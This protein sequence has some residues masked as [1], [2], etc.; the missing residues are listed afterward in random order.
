MGEYS[1]ALSYYEKALEIAQET[2]PANHPSLA[3]S[4]NNVGLVYVYLK[5]F[6][7]NIVQ[8]FFTNS[9]LY[10]EHY[11]ICSRASISFSFNKFDCDTQVRFLYFFLAKHQYEFFFKIRR[12]CL[13]DHVARNSLGR[14]QDTVAK[15]FFLN[16]EKYL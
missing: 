11:S 2:L 10:K 13:R 1:K 5:I 7:V 12:K 4:Y 6:N 3:A 15:L 9:I 16:D 14:K 8:Q